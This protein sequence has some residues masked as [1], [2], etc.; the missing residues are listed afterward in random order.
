MIKQD[1]REDGETEIE[2]DVTSRLFKGMAK[3]QTV[4]LTHG[5]KVDTLAE[6]RVT[7]FVQILALFSGGICTKSG[8]F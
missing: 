8:H 1:V 4:L 6:G 3:S 5:D 7:S 2:V